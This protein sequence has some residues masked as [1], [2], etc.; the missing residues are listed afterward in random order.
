MADE[1][2]QSW[3]SY[4]PKSGYKVLVPTMPDTLMSLDGTIE[5][6]GLFASTLTGNMTSNIGVG[7]G[8]VRIDSKNRRIIVNDGANDRVIIGYIG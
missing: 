1:D 6:N 3:D 7:G 2:V 4:L 8:N 5:T